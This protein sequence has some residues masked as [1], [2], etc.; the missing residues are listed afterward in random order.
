MAMLGNECIKSSQQADCDAEMFCLIVFYVIM[1]H[2]MVTA[3]FLIV[4]ATVCAQI[5]ANFFGTCGS[6][7][8]HLYFFFPVLG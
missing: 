7:V 6:A 1:C 3:R 2:R 4:F 8:S 5:D